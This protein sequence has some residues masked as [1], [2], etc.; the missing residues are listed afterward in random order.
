MK[1]NPISGI[2]H[3]IFDPRDGSLGVMGDELLDP[4]VV[5]R[6]GQ[7][8]MYQAGQAH[9]QG[10][11]QVFSSALPPGAPLS[12]QGW[13]PTRD[14]DGELRPL[15]GRSRSWVWDGAGGRHC[16][17]YIKGW[18]PKR[19][20]W[21]ERIYYAGAADLVRG[22]YTIGYLEWDGTQ[23]VDQAS[24]CFVANQDWEHGSVYEPNLIWHDGKWKMWY[25]AGANRENYLVH[26]YAESVDGEQ[27]EG[28]K[29]FA[30]EEMKMFDFCVRPRGNGFDAIFSR[31]H[32][33]AGEPP[34]ETGLWWCHAKK[35]SS[36]LTDWS[37]PLQIM[38]AE[39]RGWHRGPFKPSLVFH[40]NR[41]RAWVFFAG[42]Y[43]TGEPRP[44]PFAFTTG[45]LEI[46]LPT[47]H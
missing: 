2:E 41:E 7:W 25:V 20:E 31:V 39:D 27:W 4:S 37:D 23:W 24:P 1:N 42:S 9:G 34:P 15:A 28:R 36:Q 26:G 5:L 6:N 8:Y 30:P 46:D 40:E 19:K 21:V 47:S 16:P 10:A 44:F 13:A 22:P 14:T 11:P 17:A 12:A 43:N 45:C 3:K 35:P 32:V 18:N 38:T 33:G 29:L